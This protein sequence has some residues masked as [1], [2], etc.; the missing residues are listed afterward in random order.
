MILTHK[1]ILGLSFLFYGVFTLLSY[2]HVITFPISSIIAFVFIFYS[3]PTTFLSLN[4]SKYDQLSFSILIFM[5]GIIFFVISNFEIIN[6]RG[7]V[8]TSVLFIGGTIFL[9]L[10]IDNSKTKAFLFAALYLLIFGILS[11][12][13]LGKIGVLDYANKA[14]EIAEDFWPVLLIILGLNIFW[15]RKK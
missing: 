5:L 6:T 4:S 1:N 2:Y 13:Y 3:L 11:I 8:F 7:L 9:V 12:T 15:N 14:A 10:F